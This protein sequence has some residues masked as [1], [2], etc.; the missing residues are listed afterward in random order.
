MRRGL[1]TP[2]TLRGTSD[3]TSDYKLVAAHYELQIRL[4]RIQG[5]GGG[6]TQSQRGTNEQ[7]DKEKKIDE[8]RATV[9]RSVPVRCLLFPCCKKTGEQKNS[10]LDK[11]FLFPQFPIFGTGQIFDQC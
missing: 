5:K 9:N 2:D 7:E 8:P 10:Q 3:Y 1:Q 6:P 4:P 11:T